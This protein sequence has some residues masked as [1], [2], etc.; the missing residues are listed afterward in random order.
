[1]KP[2]RPAAVDHIQNWAGGEAATLSIRL[3]PRHLS[4]VLV[5]AIVLIVAAFAAPRQ[6]EVG[7]LAV[8]WTFDPFNRSARPSDGEDLLHGHTEL[9]EPVHTRVVTYAVQPGDVLSVIAGSYGV[10]TESVL[11]A[12]D[13]ADADF[14]RPG[15]RLRIPPE[16]GVLY[17]VES[18]DTLTGLAERFK[19][20]STAI[21][22]HPFNTAFDGDLMVVG[23]EIFLPGGTQPIKAVELPAP[24]PPPASAR[25]VP[26]PTPVPAPAPAS[27]APAP[28]S[29]GTLAWPAAG[30]ISQGYSAGHQAYDIAAPYRSPVYASADGVVRTASLGWN[31][32]YG[33]MVEIDHGGGIVTRYAHFSRIVVET[34]QSVQ[35]GQVIGYVG[36]TG[37]TTGPHVHYEVLSGAAKVNPGSYLR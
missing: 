19:S 26:A 15:D 17:K 31:G 11:W 3:T 22:Q 4:H 10:S 37:I 30:S 27:V 34:G 1:L 29:R 23:R 16:S 33:N 20:D 21:V 28:V 35:R 2:S 6:A 9:S 7:E 8:P 5:V 13:L 18:G 36:T 14:I 32:G 24:A 12:N 25:A